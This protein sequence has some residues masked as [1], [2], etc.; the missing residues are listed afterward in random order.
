MARSWT[1]DSKKDCIKDGHL[2]GQILA[3]GGIDNFGKAI[4]YSCCLATSISDSD[5]FRET[6]LSKIDLLVYAKINEII[7]FFDIKVEYELDSVNTEV[8]DLFHLEN[9]EKYFELKALKSII[10]NAINHVA[11]KIELGRVAVC[12][13]PLGGI[14]LIFSSQD[15]SDI[16]GDCMTHYCLDLIEM[17]GILK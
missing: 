4:D 5:Y 8:E 6:A 3:A 7:E 1:K 9:Y 13:N 2:M 12:Q 15:R 16:E 11:D 10:I 14:L 17:S